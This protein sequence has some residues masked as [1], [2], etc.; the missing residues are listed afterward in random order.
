MSAKSGPNKASF[1]MSC[2]RDEV[3][4]LISDVVNI[5]L[6]GNGEENALMG[7]GCALVSV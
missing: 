4:N 2:A 3:I 6:P 7:V 1:L 5:L